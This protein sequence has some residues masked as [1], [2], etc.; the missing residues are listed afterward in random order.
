MSPECM[1]LVPSSSA[2]D[3]FYAKSE[4]GV[5]P[6]LAS[7]TSKYKITIKYGKKKSNNTGDK[8]MPAS[9]Q[10]RASSRIAEKEQ[11]V[12]RRVDLLKDHNDDVGINSKKKCLADENGSDQASQLGHSLQVKVDKAGDGS[13]PPNFAGKS[14]YAKV[15]ETLRMFNKYYLHFVQVI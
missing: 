13:G 4:D 14:D 11:L 5:D 2:D 7:P 8:Q 12:R 9:F 3:E 15:K 10:R 1:S 6:H